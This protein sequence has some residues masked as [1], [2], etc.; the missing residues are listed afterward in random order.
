MSTH[1]PFLNRRRRAFFVATATAVL[2]LLGPMMSAWAQQVVTPE[3]LSRFDGTQWAGIR[4]GKTTR[5]DLKRNYKTQG[6]QFVRGEATILTPPPGIANVQILT[7]G[8]RGDSSAI[9]VR[10][11]YSDAG[12]NVRELAAAFKEQPEI[13]YPEERYDDWY[14]QVFPKQGI[15]LYTIREPRE[16]RIAQVLLCDPAKINSLLRTFQRETTEIKTRREFREEDLLPVEIGDVR[17]EFSGVRGVS[18]RDEDVVEDDLTEDMRRDLRSGRYMLYSRSSRG[19]LRITVSVS[20][21]NGKGGSVSASASLT[22]ETPL[23][24]ISANGYGSENVRD[25]GDN[26]RWSGTRRFE[27]AIRDA[28]ESLERDVRDKVRKQQ[29]PP[30]NVVRQTAWDDLINQVIR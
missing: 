2:T 30:L 14:V 8:R 3:P 4:F 5:D 24:K 1:N 7:N 11:Q 16:D 15:F 20:Y 29:P 26:P 19:D 13:W 21:K 25:E 10:L 28:I 23:G 22:S 17:V 18:I 9:G 6:G 12:P 27:R